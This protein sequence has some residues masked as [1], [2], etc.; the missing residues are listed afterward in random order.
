MAFV[1]P[2]SNNR[3]FTSIDITE[4]IP[5]LIAMCIIGWALYTYRRTLHEDEPPRI[6]LPRIQVPPRCVPPMSPHATS[7]TPQIPTIPH[8]PDMVRTLDTDQEVT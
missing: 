1:P 6:P 3:T 5:A 8:S 2:H 7:S 4:F